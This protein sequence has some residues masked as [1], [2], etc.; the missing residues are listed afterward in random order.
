[1]RSVLCAASLLA[2]LLVSSPVFAQPRISGGLDGYIDRAAVEGGKS[3]REV[4]EAVVE[5]ML[6][7]DQFTARDRERVGA[8]R[9]ID[10]SLEAKIIRYVRNNKDFRAAVGMK[11]IINPEVADLVGNAMDEMMA[12]ARLVGKLEALNKIDAEFAKVLAASRGFIAI[13]GLEMNETNA[14][15]KQTELGSLAKKLGLKEVAFGADESSS[16]SF[17]MTVTARTDREARAF[18]RLMENPIARRARLIQALDA[19]MPLTMLI[20]GQTVTIKYD[21]F[22]ASAQSEVVMS[23]AK[24]AAI[25]TAKDYIDRMGESMKDSQQKIL[26]VTVKYE[27]GVDVY[28]LVV[29]TASAQHFY[30]VEVPSTGKRTA[31]VS[32]SRTE[33]KLDPSS[34]AEPAAPALKAP[35][36][37]VLRERKIKVSYDYPKQLESMQG[38]LEGAEKAA[39]MTVHYWG[40]DHFADRVEDVKSVRVKYEMTLELGSD[41]FTVEI[42][43]AKAVYKYNTEISN[44]GERRVNPTLIDHSPKTTD[45]TDAIGSMPVYKPMVIDDSKIGYQLR[46]NDLKSKEK[47]A[48]ANQALSAA[49]KGYLQLMAKQTAKSVSEIQG[50]YVDA[51]HSMTVVSGTS[52]KAALP[53]IDI[54]EIHFETQYGQ[55]DF[56][57]TVNKKGESS[58][59]VELTHQWES[60]LE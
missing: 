23:G 38:F 56:K 29:D 5:T 52:G 16:S 27:D 34:K 13:V 51:I 15:E 35:T 58:A 57:V 50:F 47:M 1:M 40:Q 3:P 18:T 31:E 6:K 21:D 24:I 60:G 11:S 28:S 48:R 43:A 37:F 17:Y 42:D 55:Y 39:K 25:A 20:R 54:F 59:K 32:W 53:L 41:V 33:E 9:R 14:Y 49:M 7:S 10:F 22:G 2:A 45:L 12:H 26:S 44:Q 30:N 46:S 8:G 4:R 19:P 36:F